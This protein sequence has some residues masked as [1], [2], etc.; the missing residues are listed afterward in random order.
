MH[1]DNPTDHA[2]VGPDLLQEMEEQMVKIKE[3]LKV[4]QDR[5][6]SCADKGRTH[7]EFKVGD[8]VF[9][10]VKSMHVLH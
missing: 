7:R 1:W 6:H 3:D 2:I 5:Q 10:K 9:L 8:H 4:V